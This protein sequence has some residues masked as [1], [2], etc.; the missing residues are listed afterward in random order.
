MAHHCLRLLGAR[1]PRP[2]RPRGHAGAA[3]VGAA[4]PWPRWVAVG[5]RC[6][7]GAQGGQVGRRGGCCSKTGP[8]PHHRTCGQGGG[9]SARVRHPTMAT[10]VASSVALSALS[11]T[12][13]PLWRWVR[14]VVVAVRALRCCC[15]TPCPPWSSAPT[16]PLP[17][18]PR[19]CCHSRSRPCR[20][21]LP[22]LRRSVRR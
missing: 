4:A 8:S 7:G 1:R 12:C 11:L 19:H 9:G 22:P 14:A 21:T 15:P 10:A 2:H 20:T 5:A 6:C 13:S 18:S 17:S 3:A 16:L